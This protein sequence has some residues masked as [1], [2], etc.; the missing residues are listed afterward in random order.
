MIEKIKA[1]DFTNMSEEESQNILTDML[2]QSDDDLKN[3]INV[4]VDGIKYEDTDKESIDDLS[5]AY[6]II[7][8]NDRVKKIMEELLEEY[9]KEA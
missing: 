4:I 1:A 6:K 8:N 9:D 5:V 7:F 3:C 2:A